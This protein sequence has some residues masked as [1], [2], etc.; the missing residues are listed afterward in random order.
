M[1]PGAQEVLS[2][3]WWPFH[4]LAHSFCFKFKRKL[5][6][7]SFS[8]CFS[9]FSHQGSPHKS[10]PAWKCDCHSVQSSRIYTSELHSSRHIFKFRRLFSCTNLTLPT[11]LIPR[12]PF[13]IQMDWL[14]DALSWCDTVGSL[15][16]GKIQIFTPFSS[17]PE[18]VNSED[19]VITYNYCPQQSWAGRWWHCPPRGFMGYGAKG[20]V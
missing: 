9:Y 18:P 3:Y 14:M 19:L 20:D 15:D 16:A 2:G 8:L 10:I 6:F 1:L 5:T 12:T 17:S 7:I 13:S 11:A 4:L